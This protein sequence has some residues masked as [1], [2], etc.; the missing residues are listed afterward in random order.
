MFAIFIA[1]IIQ[2]LLSFAY[3]PIFNLI[4]ETD[5]ID[6]FMKILRI[7]DRFLFEDVLLIGFFIVSLIEVFLSYIVVQNELNKFGQKSEPKPNENNIATISILVAFI[8]AIIFAFALKIKA[9]CYLFVAITYY[10]TVFVIIF[11]AR[12]RNIVCLVIDGIS[13]LIGLVLYAALNKYFKTSSDI[14][15]FAVAPAIIAITSIFHSFL[16]KS[17]Q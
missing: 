12:E 9:V 15:L 14:I 11:Q 6:V 1:S 8:I 13:L 17:E 10:F 4:S 16:K 2:T 5:F 3:I 7:S